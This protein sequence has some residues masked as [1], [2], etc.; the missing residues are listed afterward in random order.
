MTS[1]SGGWGVEEKDET[2]MTQEDTDFKTQLK[3]ISKQLTY[4]HK[5]FS[6][7]L[8]EFLVALTSVSPTNL[9]L[10]KLQNPGIFEDNFVFMFVASWL[11]ILQ[12]ADDS[13][14]FLSLRIDFNEHYK[15]KHGNNFNGPYINRTK[16]V[17]AWKMNKLIDIISMQYEMNKDWWI[18]MLTKD[19]AK[20][21]C[22][23]WIF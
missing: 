8:G 19:E 4:T 21:L 14:K 13:M 23:I 1:L 5:T 11:S 6:D 20:V 15:Q 18:R 2:T 3:A 12:E 16:S 9:Y 17:V 10:R 7:S 22:V